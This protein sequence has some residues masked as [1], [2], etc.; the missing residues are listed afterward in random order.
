[1]LPLIN[2]DFEK[3]RAIPV[4]DKLLHLLAELF[5]GSGLQSNP[6][7]GLGHHGKIRVEHCGV[8]VPLLVEEVLPL[9]DHS[10]EII[11]QEQD[12]DRDLVLRG[13]DKFLQKTRECV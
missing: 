12:L 3:D 1:M 5:L 9:L 11:V 8:G 2:L 7:H 13:S 6:T 10:L 4:L